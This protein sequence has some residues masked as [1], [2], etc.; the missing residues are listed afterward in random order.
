MVLGGLQ[1]T[2]MGDTCQGASVQNVAPK[3]E[4]QC[5]LWSR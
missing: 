2:T 1:D 4:L 5:S 3:G